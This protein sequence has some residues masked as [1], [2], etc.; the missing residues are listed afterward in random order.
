MQEV[1]YYSC[2]NIGSFGFIII[3]IPEGHDGFPLPCFLG[4]VHYSHNVALERKRCESCEFFARM[5]A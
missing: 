5:Y 4:L 1:T 2:S 3:I